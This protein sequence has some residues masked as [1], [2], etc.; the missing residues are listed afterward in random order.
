MTPDDTMDALTGFA[1]LLALVL[2]AAA[3]LHILGRGVHF[4]EPL[5]GFFFGTQIP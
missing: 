3:W 1:V 2:C 4:G 5:S